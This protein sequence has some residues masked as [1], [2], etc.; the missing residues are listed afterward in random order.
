MW[1]LGSSAEERHGEDGQRRGERNENQ[2]LLK[3]ASQTDRERDRGEQRER[4][5]E[6]IGLLKMVF[7]QLVNNQ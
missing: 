4:K 1:W 3:R 2:Q 7:I 5:R 6:H